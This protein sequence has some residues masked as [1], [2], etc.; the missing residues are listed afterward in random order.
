MRQQS[1]QTLSITQRAAVKF[2]VRSKYVTYLESFVSSSFLLTNFHAAN[3]LYPTVHNLMYTN[4]FH[5]IIG[6]NGI[7][8]GCFQSKCI[9]NDLTF[10]HTTYNKIIIYN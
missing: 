1:E 6:I 4:I 7:P 9:F 10:Q 5:V 2:Y 3:Y 8:I